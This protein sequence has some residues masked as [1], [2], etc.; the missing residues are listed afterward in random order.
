M[1]HR[2]KIKAY[3]VLDKY[4]I[5]FRMIGMVL[6]WSIHGISFDNYQNIEITDLILYL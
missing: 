4:I 1:A 5:L 6:C 2:D 3:Y